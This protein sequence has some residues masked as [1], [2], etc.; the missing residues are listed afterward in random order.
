MTF[1]VHKHAM[2]RV[3]DEHIIVERRK[4]FRFSKV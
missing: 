3:E 1:R 4:V 2:Q